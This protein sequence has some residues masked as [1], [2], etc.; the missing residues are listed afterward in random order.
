MQVF[1]V[2]QTT[3][4]MKNIFFKETILVDRLS[5]KGLHVLTNKNQSVEELYMLSEVQHSLFFLSPHCDVQTRTPA[6]S[7]YKEE[8][9][10]LSARFSYL[11]LTVEQL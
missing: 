4:Y 5:E 2:L 10:T 9:Y 1:G 11:N 8:R 6:V 3:V 7:L